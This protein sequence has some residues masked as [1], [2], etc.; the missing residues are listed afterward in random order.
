LAPDSA[1]K[2]KKQ[3]KIDSFVA[4][5]P[6]RLLQA[7]RDNCNSKV[8]QNKLFHHLT[9]KAARAEYN[10]KKHVTPS[11]ALD[12]KMSEQQTTFLNPRF[13]DMLSGS[14][15]YDCKGKGAMQLLAK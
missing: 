15:M 9:N 1:G 11:A 12:I 2:T 13:Y 3:Q 6:K 4:T 5:F 8:V 7:Y 10:H 14:I